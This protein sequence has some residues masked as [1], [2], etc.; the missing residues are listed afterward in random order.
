MRQEP[1]TMSNTMMSRSTY[2]AVARVKEWVYM[3]EMV[4]HD[5]RKTDRMARHECRACFYAP[6][7]GG[8]AMVWRPCM[9]CGVD[10]VFRSTAT[11]V[12]CELCAVK[13]SLCKHCGGDVEMRG[14]RTDWP[15]KEV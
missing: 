12:L 1:A 6:R 3:A 11:G 7:I 2:R 10:V 8:A 4:T 14:D 9:S 15:E 5:T 13:H